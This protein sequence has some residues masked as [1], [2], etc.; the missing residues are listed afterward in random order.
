MSTPR[1]LAPGL[2]GGVLWLVCA[3]AVAEADTLRIHV[4][5][6]VN[7]GRFLE[8]LLQDF[9]AR[10]GV[11]LAISAQH[12]RKAVAA[13]RAGDTDLVITHADFRGIAALAQEGRLTDGEVVFANPIALL[14]PR[15]DP[16]GVAAAGTIEEAHAR[17]AVSAQCLVPNPLQ[18]LPALA[19]EAPGA[20]T[21]T[22]GSGAGAVQAAAARG[23]YVWWGLHPFLLT[24]QPLRPFVPADVRL[25]RP[26]MAWV[27]AG[28]RA[29]LARRALAALRSAEGQARVPAFRL[30][31]FEDLQVWWPYAALDRRAAIRLRGRL[32]VATKNIGSRAAEDHRDPAHVAKRT[33]EVRLAEALAARI[34]GDRARLEVRLL[35]KPERL[36]AVAGG[37]VDLAIAMIASD[38]PARLHADFSRPYFTDGLAVMH[39][40]GEA[41]ASAA[42]LRDRR[43][44]TLARDD[45]GVRA[46]RRELAALMG[47]ELP[48][49]AVGSFDEAAARLARHE[50]DMLVSHAAN[51]DAYLARHDDGL[52][53]SPRL[54]HSAYAVA[55]P[56]DNPALRDLVDAEIARLEASG[57]LA[58]WQREA[59]LGTGTVAAATSPARAAPEGGRG[60]GGGR[61][62]GS[63]GGGWRDARDR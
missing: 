16:A 59:G 30:A 37:G 11:T 18:H 44:L 56:K 4:V 15:A 19:A 14:G 52:A 53:R 58:A 17:I 34:A 29:A 7:Q 42:A 50:A 39:R 27:V 41:V 43:V 55:L 24:G 51:I 6:I 9:A 32:V 22:D 10:A 35:R 48:T 57:E 23:A 2:L 61:G 1:R 36:P 45:F 31:G 25:L 47:G 21:G 5:P 13:A 28:P 12:G 46:E 8:T 33:F 54:T 20:C 26:L 60:A 63:G 62:D 3:G 40:A 38:T 49:T